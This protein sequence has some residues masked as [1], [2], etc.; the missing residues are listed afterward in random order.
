MVEPPHKQHDVNRDS[1]AIPF[2]LSFMVSEAVAGPCASVRHV[3]K[4]IHMQHGSLLHP[5]ARMRPVMRRVAGDVW[6]AKVN[7]YRGTRFVIRIH[8]VSLWSTTTPADRT[9]DVHAFNGNV[10]GRV[11]RFAG[12]VPKRR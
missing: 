4:H 3:D 1:H 2:A 6:H 8:T 5:L 9:A 11:T 10:C 7:Y 12:I